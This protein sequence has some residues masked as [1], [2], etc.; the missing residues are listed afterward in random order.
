LRSITPAV[1]QELNDRAFDIWEPLLSIAQCAGG[2]WP[3]L[4]RKAAIAVS[5]DEAD[6]EETGV[7]LLRDIK[8]A[9]NNTIHEAMTTKRLIS[10]LC[11]DEERPWAT[12]GKM[13][14]GLTAKHLGELLGQFNIIS[15][16][17]TTKQTGEPKDAKGYRRVRFQEAFERYLTPA[18]TAPG[19]AAALSKGFQTSKRQ[20]ADEIATSDG[21]SKRQE[22]EGDGCEKCQKTAPNGHNDGMTL[23]SPPQGRADQK[24]GGDGAQDAQSFPA[25]CEHCGAPDTADLPV[26]PHAVDGEEHLLHRDCQADYLGAAQPK[27]DPSIPPFLQRT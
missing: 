15:E 21:F 17:A 22:T 20:S 6:V 4:A 24:N 18:K 3:E 5:G 7:R 23:E 11:A 16:T 25:V 2:E 12:Y 19:G 13:E 1:L 27:D 10:V 8:A 26:L 14:S 9:L